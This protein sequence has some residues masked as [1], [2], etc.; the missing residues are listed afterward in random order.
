MVGVLVKVWL[1][2]SSGRVVG[3]VG[4]WEL[5]YLVFL[6]VCLLACFFIYDS[7]IEILWVVYSM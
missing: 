3:R 6:F 2:W 4:D 1:G 5:A 7:M